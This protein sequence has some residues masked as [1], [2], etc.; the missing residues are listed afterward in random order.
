MWN[1]K[2]CPPFPDFLG[3]QTLHYCWRLKNEHIVL[4][5]I[6]L[7]FRYAINNID[8]IK[9][10]A[11]YVLPDMRITI[12]TSNKWVSFNANIFDLLIHYVN[13]WLT[14]NDYFVHFCYFIQRDD[15]YTRNGLIFYHGYCKIYIITFIVQNVT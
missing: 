8:F 5:Y 12:I 3:F 15:L 10:N 7:Q 6:M 14:N 11:Y 2:N 13:F 1:C 4:Y 9:L